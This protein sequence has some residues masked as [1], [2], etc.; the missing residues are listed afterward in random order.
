M[1]QF[2]IHNLKGT[3]TLDY[4]KIKPLQGNLKDLRKVNYDKLKNSLLD[5]GF[6]FPGLVWKDPQGQCWA[7][8]MHQRLRVMNREDMNDNG[9]YEIPV[10][11]IPA[12][13]KQEAK[14][15]ILLATSQYGTITQEGFDEFTADLPEFEYKDTNFDA[16]A[17]GT[18]N[19]AA[20][21]TD[22][23][24]AP[25]PTI[26]VKFDSIENLDAALDDI[27]EVAEPA[28][29]KVVVNG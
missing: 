6:T 21:D 10:V 17:F 9:S 14:K 13:N 16:L 11:Y 26:T 27:R 5:N 24:P 25:Q 15:K 28:G 19:E 3:E 23:T 22:S 12:R 7:L 20:S 1:T 4:R 2:T 8:D 29:G 18:S